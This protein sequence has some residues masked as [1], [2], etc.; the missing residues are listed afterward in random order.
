MTDTIKISREL[1]E[2][3]ERNLAS[4]D[5]AYRTQQELRAALAAPV[6]EPLTQAAVGCFVQPIPAHCDRITWRGSYYHLPIAAPVQGEAV[7]VED[8][9]W[10]DR[11]YWCKCSL[12]LHEFTGHKRQVI[13][14]VCSEQQDELATPPQPAPVQGEA[15]ANEREAVSLDMTEEEFERLNRQSIGYTNSREVLVRSLIGHFSAQLRG[16]AAPPQP[17]D[18]GELVEAL[19]AADEYLSSNRFNEIGSGS[20]LHRQMQAALAKLE[21]KA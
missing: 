21:G 15:V 18:V 7:P 6:Q 8:R 5:E 12:C 3:A 14:R 16:Y 9:G 11:D 1:L 2:R 4:G 17:A 13:C 10:P 19:R 20:I